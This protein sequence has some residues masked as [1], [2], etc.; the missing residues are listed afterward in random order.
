MDIKENTKLQNQLKCFLGAYYGV[1]IMD[2]YSLKEYM[3]K[4]ME[5]MIKSFVKMNKIEESDYKRI[6]EE[7]KDNM[8]KKT[9]L[10]DALL[11]LNDMNAPMD[12]VFQIKERLKNEKD[13][14]WRKYEKE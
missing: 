8:S 10:Q 14:E 3:L 1:S 5:E 12:L 13:K 4:D 2:E 9:K 11:V 6:E 7:V